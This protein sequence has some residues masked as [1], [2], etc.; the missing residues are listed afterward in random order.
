MTRKDRL[1][2]ITYVAAVALFWIVVIVV[3]TMS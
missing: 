2:L 1:R 3:L